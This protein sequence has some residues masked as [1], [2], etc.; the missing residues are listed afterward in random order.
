MAH[1]VECLHSKAGPVGDTHLLSQ[2][3]YAEMGTMTKESPEAH[4]PEGLAYSV[5]WQTAQDPVSNKLEDK[6]PPPRSF[7]NLSKLSREIPAAHSVTRE[8]T[9]THTPLHTFQYHEHREVRSM[10]W[11][12]REPGPASGQSGGSKDISWSGPEPTRKPLG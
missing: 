2:G 8:G 4:R 11:R 10:A 5:Q 3:P 1:W 12:P 6:D 9:C 7:S